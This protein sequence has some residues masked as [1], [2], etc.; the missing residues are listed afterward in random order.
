LQKTT[1]TT[2][3]D[4]EMSRNEVSS[5]SFCPLFPLRDGGM[6]FLLESSLEEFQSPIVPWHISL[7]F[8]IFILG[9]LPGW[10][11]G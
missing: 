3:E 10:H 4:E 11:I 2:K 5:P 8:K 7:T 1:T 6:P 9:R